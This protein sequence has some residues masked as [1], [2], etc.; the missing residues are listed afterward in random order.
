MEAIALE[1][2][3][4]EGRGKGPAR[5]LRAAGR[6]PAV[7]YGHGVESPIAV[8]LDPKALDKALEN[9]KK[10]NA[11]FAVSVDGDGSHTVLVREL[12]RHPVSRAILHLD[13]VAPDL[14]EPM[15]TS[16]P[17]VFT[18]RSKGVVVGGRL[19]TPYREVR[20][21][22]KPADIPATVEVDITE[23]D[24]DDTFYASQLALPEGVEAL[25]DRDYVVAKVLKPRAVKEKKAE[26]KKKK[27]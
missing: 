4:R 17:L 11:L 18:G 7:V 2:T 5:R 25:Y 9:P 6:V 12:Q 21:R 24:V 14:D 19:R 22:A 26:E 1:S 16:V 3:I 8:S 27:K 13:L 23:L 10:E 20:L 15:V